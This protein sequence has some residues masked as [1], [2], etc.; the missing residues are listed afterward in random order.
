M[1]ARLKDLYE[2]QIKKQLMQELSLNN[3]NQVPKLDKIVLN[4]GLGEAASDRGKVDG[5]LKDLSQIS[6]QKPI[7]TKAR[8]SVATFKLREGMNIGCKVTLRKERM[9]EFLDRLINISL[10]RVRDFHGISTKSFDKRGNYALGIKEQIVFPEINYDDVDA[11]RGMDIIICTTAKTDEAGLALLKKF[12]FPFKEETPKET[13]KEDKP[14]I[15]V[16]EDTATEEVKKEEIVDNK[17]ASKEEINA[18]NNE[19]KDN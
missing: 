10:P 11:I 12:N 9:Y 17:D 19:K 15:E 16:K 6:G 14:T 18:S 5:A 8:K 7:P 2:K 1:T 13:K 3:V 4:M